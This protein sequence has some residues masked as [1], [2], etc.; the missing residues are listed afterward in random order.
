MIGRLRSA[1]LT[2]DRPVLEEAGKYT[3]LEALDP[4]DEEVNETRHQ[5]ESEFIILQLSLCQEAEQES[6]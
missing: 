1:V 6:V 2:L 5:Q 3:D 4:G